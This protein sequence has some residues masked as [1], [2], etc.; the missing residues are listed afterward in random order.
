VL[1]VLELPS[2]RDRWLAAWRALPDDRRDVHVHPDFLALHATPQAE[3]LCFLVSDSRGTALLAALRHPLPA[4]LARPGAQCDL[5]GCPGYNGFFV[6]GSD[7]SLLADL[8][9]L[10]QSWAESN[11]AI[12]EFYRLNP[13]M[14]DEPPEGYRIV[15]RNRNVA[16]DLA[17]GPD[18]IKREQY[19]YSVRKQLAK[20][21]RAGLVLGVA[22]SPAEVAVAFDVYA[23]TMERNAAVNRQSLDYFMRAVALPDDLATL[24]TVARGDAVVACELVTHGARVAYSY[25][26]GTLAE[27]FA[28]APNELIKHGIVCDQHAR[29]RRWFLLGGGMSPEDGIH[30]YKRKFSPSHDLS[31][32]V[33]SRIR[34]PRAYDQVLAQWSATVG[35]ESQ[36]YLAMAL[37]YR[38]P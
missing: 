26:G 24:Y 11:G 28:F 33:A 6:A 18:A 27:A 14:P 20:A 35:T 36:R 29:G 31:F 19:E 5:Q 22:R 32:R 8:D 10:V 3:P 30:R 15:E 16:I 2:G 37:P 9:A 12:A 1:S 7:P 4:E 21:D 17:P 23:H 13:L 25:L 34:L 38:F